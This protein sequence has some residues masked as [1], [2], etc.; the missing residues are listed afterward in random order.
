MN[1][2]ITYPIIRRWLQQS[3]L[4]TS[5]LGHLKR[6]RRNGDKTSILLCT[7]P[8]PPDLPSGMNFSH[9]YQL[10][11]PLTAALTLSSLKLKSSLWPTVYAPRRKGDVEGWSKRM[12]NWAWRAVEML[13]QEAARARVN[14]EVE[15]FLIFYA[16]MLIYFVCQSSFRLPPMFHHLAEWKMRYRLRHM[17][18][19]RQPHIVF[20]TPP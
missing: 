12:V 14:G 19:E 15:P 17:T 20:A 13:L 1:A 2:Y 10:P 3:A 7:S 18:P 5:E 6:V 8:S 16:V 4:Q 11:V 9:P